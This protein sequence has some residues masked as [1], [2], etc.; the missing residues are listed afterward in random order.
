MVQ[1]LSGVGRG[2]RSIRRVH[3][4]INGAFGDECGGE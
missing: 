2:R 1:L 3:G 4:L